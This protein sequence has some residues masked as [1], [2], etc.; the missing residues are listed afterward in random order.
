MD[1]TALLRKHKRYD[2]S[3][4]SAL[5]FSMSLLHNIISNLIIKDCKLTLFSNSLYRRKRIE[6]EIF[7]AIEF[8]CTEVSL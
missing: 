8:H 5:T 2:L 3:Y 1:F 7:D 4:T 6:T